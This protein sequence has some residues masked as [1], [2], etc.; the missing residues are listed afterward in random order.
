MTTSEET[1]RVEIEYFD[2]SSFHE[3]LY[4]REKTENG[5]LQRFIEPKGTRNS[6]IRAIWSPKVCLLERRINVNNLQD[7][8]RLTMYDRACTYEGPQV[9]SVTAPVR[10]SI[11]PSQV[12]HVSVRCQSIQR[13][14][15][16]S[17]AS[18]D[19]VQS[20]SGSQ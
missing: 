19:G 12:Q 3:F 6:M 11:L 9:A 17:T 20:E 7:N 14:L 5:V 13:C 2:K 10:G 8:R 16:K 4:K 15:F 1:G 18:R